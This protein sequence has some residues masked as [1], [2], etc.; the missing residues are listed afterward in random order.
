M[1]FL[2]YVS[3]YFSYHDHHHQIHKQFIF[4][5]NVLWIQMVT[6]MPTTLHKK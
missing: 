6:I 1:K 2:N 3:V 4:G 5:K